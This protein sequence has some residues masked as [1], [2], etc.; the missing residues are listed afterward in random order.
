MG[1]R[2]EMREMYVVVD[3]FG[4]RVGNPGTEEEAKDYAKRLTNIEANPFP[5]YSDCKHENGSWFDRTIPMA[6]VCN[7]CGVEV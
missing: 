5:K 3:D 1:Y 7:D 2:V 4:K 6:Y